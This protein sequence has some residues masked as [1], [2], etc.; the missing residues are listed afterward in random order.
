MKLSTADLDY[1]ACLVGGPGDDAKTD[2]ELVD[3]TQTQ[4]DLID[5]GQDGTEHY[6]KREIA[7]IRRWLRTH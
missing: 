5:E 3:V 2:S 6:T 1:P 7:A 4:L